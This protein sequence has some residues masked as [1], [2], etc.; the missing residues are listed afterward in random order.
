MALERIRQLR[1]SK[2]MTFDEAVEATRSG[3]VFTVHTLVKAG[4]DEF[5][6]E[7]M[8]KYFGHYFPHLGVNRRAVPLAGT[9]ASR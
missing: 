1:S 8:D 7:L 3:N 4:L 5:S 6:V 9:D 2:N